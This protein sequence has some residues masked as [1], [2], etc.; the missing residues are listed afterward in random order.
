[1]RDI[2][3][4]KGPFGCALGK[5]KR[6]KARRRNSNSKANLSGMKELIDPSLAL[7]YKGRNFGKI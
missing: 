6:R 2:G 5:R 4:T 3:N 1:L 7:P